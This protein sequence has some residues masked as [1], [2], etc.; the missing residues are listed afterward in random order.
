MPLLYEMTWD[1]KNSR[2]RRTEKGKPFV[3][4]VRQLRK[5]FNDPSIPDTKEGLSVTVREGTTL[6][7][8]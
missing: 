5:A 8:K 1:G 3:V 4:S 7:A 6:P 2:W